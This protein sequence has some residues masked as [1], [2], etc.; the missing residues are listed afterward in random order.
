MRIAVFA[1][2]PVEGVPSLVAETLRAAGHSVRVSNGNVFSGRKI[3]D[4]RTE[5]VFVAGARGPY[6]ALVRAAKND[7][8]P[9]FILDLS[10]IRH[11]DW[12]QLA[13]SA[14][15]NFPENGK[16]DRLGLSK[17]IK[18]ISPPPQPDG[19]LLFLGQKPGDAQHGMDD[20]AVRGYASSQAH[21]VHEV[22]PDLVFY[23]KHH[24]RTIKHNPTVPD[25]FEELPE[26]LR[27]APIPAVLR[28][29]RP[30]AVV[31]YNSTGAFDALL[32][33][34]P[35]FCH[36]RAFYAGVAETDISG[37]I[38]PESALASLPKLKALLARM[39]WGI[40]GEAELG[41]GAFT[42]HIEERVESMLSELVGPKEQR[43]AE[44][45]AAIRRHLTSVAKERRRGGSG[46]L[47]TVQVR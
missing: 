5:A 23:F 41:E 47:R 38:E 34:Y 33:R 36:E 19:P 24:P 15:N 13:E 12:F 17:M 30:R 6:E 35:V 37:V 42:K 27:T 25:G 28:E 11:G 43:Q 29:I 20:D 45:D 9:C 3:G 1:P 8:I 7:L 22:L 40:W 44:T 16:P 32:G 39:S 10:P 18:P 2:D 26:N 31:T 21:L 46:L 4:S 14:L